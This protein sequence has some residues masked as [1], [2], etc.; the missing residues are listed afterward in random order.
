[1][2]DLGC[3][4]VLPRVCLCVCVFVGNMQCK[5]VN[6][7]FCVRLCV[8]ARASCVHVHV[9]VF[10]HVCVYECVCIAPWSCTSS[11][12]WLENLPCMCH[13]TRSCV[14]HNS[15][16]I[17]TGFTPDGSCHICLDIHIYDMYI[18][19]I[20]LSCHKYT[21]HRYECQDIYGM[22]HLE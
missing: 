3:A 7:T 22:S 10:V 2:C 6:M 13:M 12:H 21:C 18:Y 11:L 19:D 4:R 20:H 17:V 8:C 15:F 5:H 9:L 1:M 14:R 16:V